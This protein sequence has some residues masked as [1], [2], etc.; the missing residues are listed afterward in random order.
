MLF[1]SIGDPKPRLLDPVAD[2]G[3]G[4]VIKYNHD[5]TA[6]LEFEIGRASCRERV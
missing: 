3:Q 5:S 6:A 2:E 1:R 4:D